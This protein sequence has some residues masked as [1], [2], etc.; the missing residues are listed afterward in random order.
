ML[1]TALAMTGFIFMCSSEEERN[2]LRFRSYA[3]NQLN[4]ASERLHYILHSSLIHV[5]GLSAFVSVN[6]EITRTEFDDFAKQMITHHKNIHSIELVKGTVIT[7]YIYPLKGNESAIGVDLMS[8]PAD[9]ETV[10]HAIETR[11]TVIAG[12]LNLIQGGTGFISRTP[13]FISSG[14]K[15]IQKDKYWG[16]AQTIITTEAVFKEADLYDRPSDLH[17]AIRGRDAKGAAGEVFFGDKAV[18]QSNPLTL[19]IPLFSGSWQLAVVPK[20]GWKAVSVIPL[21]LKALRLIIS[22]TMGLLVFLFLRSQQNV[23]KNEE[24]YRNIFNNASISIWEED[25]ADVKTAIDDLKVQGVMD[26]RRYLNENPDFARRAAQTLK[27]VDINNATIKLYKAKNK[28]ELLGFLDRVF[29]PESYEAFKEILIAI[30]EGKT[31]FEAEA[32][33][34]NMQ[35]E[36]INILFTCSIPSETSEFR[37]LLVS[38]LDISERKRAETTIREKENRLRSLTQTAVDAIISAD[39]A[40]NII[41]WNKGAQAIFGYGEDEALGKPLAIL[42]PERYRDAHER[43]LER[44][45]AGVEARI[46]GKTIERHG[47]RK[48]G[49]EFPLEL[50]LATWKTEMGVFFTGIIRDI[51]ERKKMEAELEKS[52]RLEAIGTLAG[53]IA[54]DFNNLL[55]AILGNIAIT[56]M[57]MNSD[58]KD[59]DKLTN[60]EDACMKA[61]ELTQ[62][63]ITFSKGGDPIL[64]P[65]SISEIAS[66][67]VCP[68][69]SGSDI[70]C[71]CVFPEHLYPVY[72]DEGQIRQVLRNMAINAKEAMPHGGVIRVDAENITLG[73]GDIAKLKE[74]KY[75]KVSIKDSGK[76]IPE[77]ILPKIFD[78]YFTTKEMGAERGLG[79][80]LAVCYSIVKKHNGHIA[81]ESKTGEGTTFHVYLPASEIEI[82]G[83]ESLY[84]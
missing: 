3:L 38:I 35:G 72:V 73:K 76:G 4:T 33:N 44:V 39:T 5:E 81:V 24:R 19:E 36:P 27:I 84:F 51:T 78:P 7:G 75:V 52:R 15:S 66:E 22:L 11:K 40:G 61:T 74:G 42:I 43:G 12:P 59:F 47:L 29:T 26:F 83:R 13:I 70:T 41:S 28:A 62:R 25:F 23:L 69:M 2:F 8:L 53:G 77:E 56:K 71:E 49:G 50:S 57:H 16:L 58:N 9:R 55:T 65:V 82:K 18:F 46:I 60:A 80:G 6:P 30:A 10:R 17:F 45:S 67:I 79:L 20:A 1:V 64:H 63:I 48:N 54:H 14:K 31:Y 32:I 34:K 37:N 21:W 68:M